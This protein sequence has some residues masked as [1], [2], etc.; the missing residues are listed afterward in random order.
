MGAAGGCGNSS[1]ATGGLYVVVHDTSMA[2]V[3][4]AVVTTDPATKSLTTDALG[5]VIFPSVSM[6]IYKVVATHPTLGSAE[7]AVSVTANQLT[8]VILTDRKSVV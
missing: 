3:A 8:Q 2:A 5:S 7:S 6:G 1:Q 4:D